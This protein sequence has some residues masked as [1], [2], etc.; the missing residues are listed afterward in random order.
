MWRVRLTGDPFDLETLHEFYESHEPLVST[1]GDSFYIESV[2]FDSLASDPA[3]LLEHAKQL[4]VQLNGAATI[5]RVNHRPVST[6]GTILGPDGSQHGVVGVGTLHLRSKILTPTLISGMPDPPSAT[7]AQVLFNASRG[8]PVAHT[9]L[10]R[11][12]SGDLSVVNLWRIWDD[13]RGACGGQ[14]EVIRLGLATEDEIDRFG[15]TANYPD[16]LGDTSRHGGVGKGP[17]P[18]KRMDESETLPF[19][20]G[21]VANWLQTL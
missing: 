11:L 5:V 21:L 3:Q 2:E 20:S 12:G 16:I 1:D 10:Q 18:R 17:P 8:N 13:I 4:V 9:V 15:A 7:R 19:I 6:D 14:A